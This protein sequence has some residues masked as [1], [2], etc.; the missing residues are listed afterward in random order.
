MP[1]TVL[2][3]LLPGPLVADL[4]E[5]GGATGFLD[6]VGGLRLFGVVGDGFFSV[7][8]AVVCVVAGGLGGGGVEFVICGN[9]VEVIGDGRVVVMVVVVVEV[10]VL[11]VVVEVVGLV[12]V[13][14]G[15]G[16]V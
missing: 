8:F 11:V 10:V 13:G 9:F 4:G 7:V 3:A 16:N 12:V 14:V 15:V 2:F 6:A 5:V 1:T